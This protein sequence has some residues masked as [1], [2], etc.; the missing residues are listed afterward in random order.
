MSDQ[1]YEEARAFLAATW[2]VAFE[3]ALEP[4]PGLDPVSVLAKI[5]RAHPAQARPGLGEPVNDIL[6]II[7][8]WAPDRVR[9]LDMELAASGVATAT[10]MLSGYSRKIKRLLQSRTLTKEEDCR[11][12]RTIFE[13][14]AHPVVGC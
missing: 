3:G 8:T 4:P 13:G 2:R 1:E 10:E 9:I 6:G 11:L 14:G 7:G 5:E 12:L